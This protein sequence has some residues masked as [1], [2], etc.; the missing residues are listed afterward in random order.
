MFGVWVLGF[1]CFVS[2]CWGVCG[3]GVVVVVASLLE[4]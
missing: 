4:R 3:G 2:G 1:F